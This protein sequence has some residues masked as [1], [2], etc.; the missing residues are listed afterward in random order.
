L[1]QK[2]K[3]SGWLAFELA[4]GMVSL[5]HVHGMNGGQPGVG[6]CESYRCEGGELTTLRRLRKSLGLDGYRCTLCLGFDA[7]QFLQVEAPEVPDEEVKEALRWS[8]KGMV[9]FPV[10]QATLDVLDVPMDKEGRAKSRFKFVAISRNEVIGRHVR[11]F[12]DAGLDLAAIDIPE[13]AQRNLAALYEP[14][15]RAVAML[16]FSDQGGLLTFTWRGRLLSSRHIDISLTQ[17]TGA[18]EAQRTAMFERIGL[19]LQ[20]SLDSFERQSTFVSLDKL[21]VTPLA[22]DIGLTAYLAE[23]LYVGVMAA[24]LDEVLD[25]QKVPELRRPAL[26]AQRLMLLGSALRDEGSA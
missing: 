1:F 8:M 12:Q 14:Q 5:A 18:D 13:M 2:R 22:D 16:G 17:L 26:Q 15:D 10:D 21:V 23:N 20:R 24:K 3:K 11:L 7:Y 6:L 4:D 25:V 9:D 19:E